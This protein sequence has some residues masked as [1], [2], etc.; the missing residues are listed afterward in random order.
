MYMYMILLSIDIIVQS[1]T[2]YVL[3]TEPINYMLYFK[4]LQC[5]FSILEVVKIFKR[6]HILR[7][8]L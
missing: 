3:L 6:D 1:I 5:H 4:T 8:T 2:D 7:K